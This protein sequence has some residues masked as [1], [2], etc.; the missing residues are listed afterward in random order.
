M[1][2]VVPRS[3]NRRPR[4]D[5][6]RK[7]HVVRLRRVCGPVHVRLRAAHSGQTLQIGRLGRAGE[8]AVAEVLVHH[9]HDV[10]VGRWLL[11]V[12]GEQ[13]ARS[14]GGEGSGRLQ[15]APGREQDSGG[16]REHCCRSGPT[17]HLVPSH[18]H[19]PPSPRPH[20]C[21]DLSCRAAGGPALHGSEVR[22][23]L[24]AADGPA[25]CG[26]SARSR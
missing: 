26:V 22:P 11:R 24:G 1:E 2:D 7:C 3:V 21:A 17:P 15:W 20:P 14:R 12:E 23:R 4:G 18:H 25:P 16:Q 5:T 6:R 10:L 8:P 19:V 9:D 13:S